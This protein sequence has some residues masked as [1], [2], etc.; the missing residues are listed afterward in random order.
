MNEKVKKYIGFVK[1]F[2][3]K[4]GT[5]R[6]GYIN[7]IDLGDVFVHDSNTLDK[8]STYD[9]VLFEYRES[10]KNKEKYEAYNVQLVDN[11]NCLEQIIEYFLNENVNDEVKKYLHKKLFIYS[12][13]TNLLI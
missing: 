13:Q 2:G 11:V 8:I 9:V 4:E 5:L 12:E 10:G 3:N 6:Y 1:W 7:N